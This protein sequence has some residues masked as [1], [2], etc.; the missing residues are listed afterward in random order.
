M[1]YNIYISIEVNY[2]FTDELFGMNGIVKFNSNF[3]INK[4]YYDIKIEIY[5]DENLIKEDEIK[6]IVDNY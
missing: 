1:W 5:Y 2:G 4:K 3:D 6:K